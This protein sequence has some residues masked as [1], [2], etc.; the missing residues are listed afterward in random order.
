MMPIA[1]FNKLNAENKNNE[2]LKEDKDGKEE[3]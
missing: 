3:R 1:D 2:L